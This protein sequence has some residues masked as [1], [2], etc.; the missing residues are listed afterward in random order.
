V[1][2][3]SIAKKILVLC[4]ALGFALSMAAC[5]GSEEAKTMLA[6]NQEYGA[7]EVYESTGDISIDFTLSEPLRDVMGEEVGQVLDLFKNWT[8]SG[9]TDALKFVSDVSVKSGDGELFHII[10]DTPGGGY[11]MDMT[12]FLDAIIAIDPEAGG[13]LEDDLQGNQWVRFGFGEAVSPEV[14]TKQMTALRS[15]AADY[16]AGL[17]NEVFADY[18]SGLV[19]KISG[20][21]QFKLTYEQ[22]GSYLQ[23]LG[24]YALEHLDAFSVYTKTFIQGLT[25]ED[26]EVLGLT[27]SDLDELIA[28]LD[29]LA[30]PENKSLYEN[31]LAGAVTAIQMPEAAKI[32]AGTY[33]D[34]QL[35]KKGDA[36][37]WQY[38][39][40][41][42]ANF[43]GSSFGSI[44]GMELGSNSVRLTAS[45]STQTI[46]AFEPELPT[47]S[48]I[49][50]EDTEIFAG[51]VMD[52]P[53]LLY[54]GLNPYDPYGDFDDYDWAED[55]DWEDEDWADD[56]NL[57]DE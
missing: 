45:E 49:D 23:S 9:R 46:A 36:F 22:M 31:Y 18:D 13:Y 12:G 38:D 26:K 24:S 6:L 2:K 35:V 56:Y 28:W 44:L 25:A 20:G 3:E 33:I 17:E 7:L 19:T 4:L 5:G 30:T 42:N 40:L 29:E 41:I 47:A 8:Y 50:A 11:Y 10:M 48:V 34:L 39:I 14:Y 57:E 55:Y 43:E 37:V 52:L 27:D 16:C 32:L 53:S 54:G 21:F 1:K 51:A 15:L